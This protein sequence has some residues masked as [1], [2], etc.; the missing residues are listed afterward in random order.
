D[1]WR[2][3]GVL[4][5]EG[6]AA[7]ALR[8]LVS[9]EVLVGDGECS[10]TVDL[11]R[12]WLNRHRRLDW[13]KDELA[14]TVA[15]WNRVAEP[16]PADTIPARSDEAA[17]ARGAGAVRLRARE[18]SGSSEATGPRVRA[19]ARFVLLAAV[20]VAVAAYLTATSM[21]GVFPFSGPAPAG[22]VPTSAQN[23]TQLLP[24]SLSQ[25]PSACRRT[26]APSAWKAPGLVEALYCIDPGLKGGTIYAYQFGNLADF[27][28]AW[29]SFNRWWK[30]PAAPAATTCPPAGQVKARKD[31]TSN[32][33]P[34]AD[35]QVLE[36][37]PVRL[38]SG[39]P[40]PMYAYSFPAN[41][42]L[43]IA[44]GAPSSSFS[45]LAF[46]VNHTTAQKHG[47]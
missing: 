3:I 47:S 32:E 5:P 8:S 46:W 6:E 44:Q 14:E 11:Q 31:L 37:G 20:I 9:R 34:E 1:E 27:Q 42:T 45:A 41:D 38:G 43:V 4:L 7:R 39:G 36:C 28:S 21:A 35:R 23:L 18:P 22:Q 40:V 12:L 19:R 2:A 26:S 25:D 29:Q 30:F 17:S 10:F 33:V 13:V 24:G 16:W 15:Q